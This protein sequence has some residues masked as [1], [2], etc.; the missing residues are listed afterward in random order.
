M[1]ETQARKIISVLADGCDP[2]TGEKLESPVLQHGDVIRALHVAVRAL[3]ARIKGRGS[4]ARTPANAGKPWTEEEDR[5]QAIGAVRCGPVRYAA[6][7][8]A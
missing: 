7:A 1:D 2:M 3:E 6:G 5:K 8:G 4:R